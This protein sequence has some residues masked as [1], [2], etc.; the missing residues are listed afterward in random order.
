MSNNRRSREET[1]SNLPF[2]KDI[3]LLNEYTD[4]TRCP[5][6]SRRN[7]Y[8]TMGPVQYFIFVGSFYHL[9]LPN[10]PEEW[11]DNANSS[12]GAFL[13]DKYGGVHLCIDHCVNNYKN[14]FTM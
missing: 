13:I 10:P 3:S 7:Q 5:A 14:L 2:P 1:F 12:I 4:T 8:Y 11:R 6:D 9:L